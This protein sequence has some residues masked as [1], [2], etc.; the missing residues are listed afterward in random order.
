MRL[1]SNGSCGRKKHTVEITVYNYETVEQ[2]V[3]TAWFSFEGSTNDIANQAGKLALQED[4]SKSFRVC[5]YAC[6]TEAAAATG[7]QDVEEIG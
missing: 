2:I 4:V 7:L 3:G 5:R 1:T 6:C